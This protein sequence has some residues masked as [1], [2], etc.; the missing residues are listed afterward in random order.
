[1]GLSEAN[2]GTPASVGA[3]AVSSRSRGYATEKRSTCVVI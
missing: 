3:R 2:V 1:M